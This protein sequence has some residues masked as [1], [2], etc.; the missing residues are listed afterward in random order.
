MRNATFLNML[1]LGLFLNSY[2][3]EN[4]IIQ[5]LECAN[6]VC[7]GI[8]AQSISSTPENARFNYFKSID[9]LIAVSDIA[10]ISTAD[11]F[12]FEIASKS[13]KRGVIPIISNV[14]GLTSPLLIQLQQLAIEMGIKVGFAELGYNFYF[15]LD[16]PFIAKINRSIDIKLVDEKSFQS[17]LKHD[18]A[19]ALKISKLDIRKVRAYGLPLC[20]NIPSNLL[21]MVDF[22]NNSVFTYTTKIA[23]SETEITVEVYTVISVSLSAIL[24][25]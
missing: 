22:N 23:D 24:V 7:A 8:W 2:I 21:V 10:I 25:V 15:P 20:A 19:T 4:Q 9:D 16:T 12:K 11:E 14:N 13:I 5:L 1:K 3:P 18:L 17:T 6:C